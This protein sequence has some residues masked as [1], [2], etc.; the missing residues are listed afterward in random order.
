MDKQ[1]IKKIKK[2]DKKAFRAL[3]DEYYQAAMRASISMLKNESDASDAVQETFIRVYKG[4]HTY[5]DSKPFKPWFY[6]I[7]TN[8]VRRLVSKR[9][10]ETD[11]DQVPQSAFQDK[12]TH[13]AAD[14]EILDE[15]MERL[16]EDH[17]EALVLKYVEGLSEKEMSSVLEISVG[18]VKSRLFKARK[19][20]REELRG[21][22]HGQEQF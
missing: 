8:E 6:R 4:I 12:S 9:K 10:P 15:A 21:D 14:N 2:G 3:Y 19:L 16:K 11:I 1:T 20:L 18:A 13:P 17:R 22:Y 7:L 5:D